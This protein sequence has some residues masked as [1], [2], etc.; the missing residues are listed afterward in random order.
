MKGKIGK[1]NCSFKSKL[2]LPALLF[3][4]C[5]FCFLVGFF[6]SSLFSQVDPCASSFCLLLDF[7]ALINATVLISQFCHYHRMD[8]QDVNGDRPRP[9]MLHSVS[10]GSD[11]DPMPYGEGGDDSISSIPFQVLSIWF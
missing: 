9:R 3:V 4:V 7:V 1:G 10:D 6:G 11:Y 2:G 5:L 8:E